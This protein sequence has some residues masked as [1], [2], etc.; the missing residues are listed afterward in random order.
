MTQRGRSGRLLA[1]LTG[2]WHIE[3]LASVEEK[4]GKFGRAQREELAL[5]RQ[6]LDELT[7]ALATR[8]GAD[9]LEKM[10][11]R[12]EDVHVSLAQQDRAFS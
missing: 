6:R 2:Q 4:V 10:R 9:E 8:A 11:R 1:R 7:A 3:R 5:Q 12:L